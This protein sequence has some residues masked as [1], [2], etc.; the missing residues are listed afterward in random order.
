MDVHG[1]IKFCTFTMHLPQSETLQERG[2]VQDLGSPN[3]IHNHCPLLSAG[4]LHQHLTMENVPVF[5]G[6]VFGLSTILAVLLFYQAAGN[7]KSTMVVLL[8]WL[9]LQAAV[10]LTGFY[11]VTAG[12]PP[13]FF[14]LTVPPLVVIIMLFATAGGRRYLDRLDAKTLMLLHMVRVPVE[15]VLYSL[16]VYKAVP[17]LLTF[18]GRNFDILSGLS[19]PLIYYFGFVKERI[20][21]SLLLLWNLVCLGLLVNVVLSAVFSAPFAFQRFGFDQ[22]NRAVLYFP[23]VWLPCCVV[24]L[25][26]LAHLSSIRQ[27][28][29]V[30]RMKTD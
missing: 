13:R 15:L 18:E 16:F 12:F 30:Q 20:P 7:S 3:K 4:S 27:L 1:F 11:T 9:A 25:V 19:A 21:V 29:I 8:L 26:L 10:S 28:I 6:V 2:A 5:T 23:Y 22:P 14:L 24:P 17:Q